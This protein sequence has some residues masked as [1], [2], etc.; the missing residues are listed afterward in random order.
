MVVE[1]SNRRVWEKNWQSQKKGYKRQKF[2]TKGCR[3]EKKTGQLPTTE[4]KIRA[5]EKNPLGGGR[6]LKKKVAHSRGR[7]AAWSRR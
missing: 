7:G 6:E 5:V 1:K 4:K 3:Q 2:A